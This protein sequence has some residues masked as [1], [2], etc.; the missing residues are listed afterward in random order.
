[1]RSLGQN[2]TEEEISQMMAEADEDES[3]EI[4]FKEFCMLMGKRRLESE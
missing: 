3:G 4:D 2:P 1:M